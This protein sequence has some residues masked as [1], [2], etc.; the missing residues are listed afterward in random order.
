MACLGGTWED[1]KPWVRFD[2]GMP[3]TGETVMGRICDPKS[4][5]WASTRRRLCHGCP[6]YR[7]KDWTG[8]IVGALA[9]D[10]ET[11]LSLKLAEYEQYVRWAEEEMEPEKFYAWLEEG[12]RGISEEAQAEYMRKWRAEHPGYDK[13]QRPSRAA[14]QRERRRRLS[15]TRNRPARARAGSVK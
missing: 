4:M 7:G 3:A 10:G 11:I 1:P 8:Q 13:R 2:G 15:E 5:P 12:T 9:P 6:A 14:Y